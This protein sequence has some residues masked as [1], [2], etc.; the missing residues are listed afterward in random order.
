MKIFMGPGP[1]L[2]HDWYKIVPLEQKLNFFELDPILPFETKN[3]PL[4]QI[5]P[6]EQNEKNDSLELLEEKKKKIEN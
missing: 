5:I 2:R 6:L 1:L 4:E 3:V